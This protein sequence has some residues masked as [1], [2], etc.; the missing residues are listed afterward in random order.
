M[1][2]GV[3]ASRLPLLDKCVGAAV[4]PTVSNISEDGAIGTAKHAHLEMRVKSGLAEAH[5]LMPA[6]CERH[7]LDERDAGIAAAQMRSFL[8][9]PPP[10][11]LAEVSLCLLEDGQVVRVAG[12]R[13]S[14]LVLPEGAMLPGQLDVMWSEP[15][16]LSVRDDGSVECPAGSTLFVY[17]FKT[18][19]DANVTTVARNAQVL[20]LGL[21]AQRWTGAA[22]VVVGVIY[23]RPGDGEWDM[24][25]PMRAETMSRVEARIRRKLDVIKQARAKHAA[26][27]HIELVEGSHCTYC[28]AQ[29]RCPAKTAMIKAVATGEV[30]Q[31]DAADLTPEQ[32]EWVATRLPSIARFVDASRDALRT[33][34]RQNGP[35]PMGDGVFWG[36]VNED[37]ETVDAMKAKPVLEEELGP[38]AEVAIKTTLAK[39]AIEDAIAEKHSAEGIKRQKSAA[40]RRILAKLHAAGAVGSV[41]VE[42]FKPYRPAKLAMRAGQGDL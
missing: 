36:P 29:S 27:E 14:Y 33:Y 19:D 30:V 41:R 3:S 42:M 40:M 22:E 11:A 38:H 2:P 20:S 6:I 23:P 34:V 32:A 18:G 21:M 25:P 8:W 26:G 24:T 4:L 13:G 7:G 31:A 17:D 1:I 12:G 37:R 5:R 15:E 28:P 39:S 16:P 35:V 10:G 9:V